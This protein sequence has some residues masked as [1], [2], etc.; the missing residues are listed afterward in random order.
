M[1]ASSRIDLS[2]NHDWNDETR[3]SKN[4]EDGDFP[5]LKSIMTSKRT[6]ITKKYFTFR[7]EHQQGK[8]VLWQGYHLQ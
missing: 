1:T 5:V 7:G 6:P 3:D 4:F 2:I 8:Q